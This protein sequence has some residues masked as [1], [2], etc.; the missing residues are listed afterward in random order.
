M[1]NICTII[2]SIFILLSFSEN[3]Y[4]QVGCTDGTE[5]EVVSLD[6]TGKVSAGELGS[7]GNGSGTLCFGNGLQKDI[8]AMDWAGID[9]NPVGQSWCSEA[10]IYFGSNIVV[11]TPA[12]SEKSP[13][14]CANNYSSGYIFDLGGQGISF[15]TDVSGCINWETFES[16]DDD[17][18]ATADQIFGAGT[19]KLYACPLGEVLPVELVYFEATKEEG[20]AVLNWETASE[21]NNLGFNVEHST[22]GDNFRPIGWIEGAGTTIEAQRYEFVDENPIRGLN[23]YR[24]VQKDIDGSLTRFD[25]EV[26][27]FESKFHAAVYPNPTRL[28]KETTLRLYTEKKQE[29]TVRVYDM[30]GQLALEVNYNLQKGDN[31]VILP[32]GD[33]DSGQYTVSVTHDERIIEDMRLHI[34]E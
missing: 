2:L 3:T 1:K 29:V 22:D 17:D 9:V 23:Y 20:I 6:L 28:R 7:Q 10:K 32:H 5:A 31:K 25:V 18:P 14:P 30:I 4:S 19:F 12:A 8:V 13:G 11:L 27:T 34:L 21:E 26:L 15:T 33:M 16:I 24:L